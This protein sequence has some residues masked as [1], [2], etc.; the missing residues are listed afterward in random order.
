M[1]CVLRWLCGAVMRAHVRRFG[2]T[3]GGRPSC[4]T[5]KN[6]PQY[7]FS[8]DGDTS[9]HLH[10]SLMQVCAS[11]RASQRTPESNVSAARGTG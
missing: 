3:A 5:W 9:A 4:S 2:E 7:M 10:V 6:N 8:V 1:V 11:Q